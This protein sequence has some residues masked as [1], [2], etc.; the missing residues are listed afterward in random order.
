VQE[1]FHDEDTKN[2]KL[3]YEENILDA[4]VLGKDSVLEAKLEENYQGVD[5]DKEYH[6]N[7]VGFALEESCDSKS[8]AYNVPAVISLTI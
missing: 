7:V 8:V 4:R 3:D 1:N 5:D 6:E 2:Y